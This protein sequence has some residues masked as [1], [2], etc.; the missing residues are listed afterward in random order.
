LIPPDT[1]IAD[2]LR[3]L[4]SD[5]PDL[6]KEATLVVGGIDAADNVPVEPLIDGLRSNS[7][8]TVFW[9]AI[10]LGRMGEQARR[11][12]PMLR[13][14]VAEYY[15]FGTRQAA[16]TALGRIAPDDR[17]AKHSVLAAFADLSPFV[18]REAL[19]AMIQ[20][21]NLDP[22]DLAKIKEMESDSDEAVASW[23][24][25]ALRNIRLRG[26]KEG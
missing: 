25:I 7:E 13:E 23:S 17:E 5:D 11:A 4:D 6:R 15:Q 12:V 3:W 24:E 18:R 8:R 14:I 16:L 21:H 1:T 20:F 10:A 26:R 19:Q 2:W 9:A 22:G